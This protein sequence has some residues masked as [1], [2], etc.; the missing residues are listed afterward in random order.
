MK[1]L[2]IIASGLVLAA[3]GGG[4]GGTATGSGGT[5]SI[6]PSVTPATYNLTGQAQ[7]GPLIFGSRIWV[8]ELDGSLNPNGKIFLAQ[9]KDDLGNFVISST[10]GT[11]LVEL[12]GMGYYMDELTG[13][14]ST[15]PV[16]LSA[17]ADLSVDNTPTINILTTLQAPRLKTLILQ[18]KT[19]AQAAVQS[20]TE[21]LAAFGVNSSKIESLNALYAMQINGTNDQDS[22]LLAASAILSK[23]STTAATTNG[24]S[25][26]AEMTY[27]L[28]RIA[29]D[30]QNS[31]ALT[32]TSIITARNTASTQLDLVAVR[33][34]V[35]TYY[36]N[37][38]LTITAPKFEEWVDKDGSGILPRR[39]VPTSGLTFTTLVNLEHSQVVTSNQVTISGLGSGVVA[40]LTVNSGTTIIKNSAA[41]SG[42]SSTVQDGDVVAVRRTSSGFGQ[43]TTAS[44]VAGSTA[45]T[46][47]LTTKIPQIGYDS[48]GGASVPQDA[49]NVY[50]AVPIK[51]A[52]SFTAHYVGVGVGS[53]PTSFSIYSDNAGVPG[54]ALV[55]TNTFGSYFGAALTRLDGSSFS[56]YSSPQAFLGTTGVALTASTVYWIVVQY[57]VAS[58]PG[59]NNALGAN[60]TGLNR[61]MSTDGSTWVNW[62]GCCNGNSDNYNPAALPG[63][64]LAN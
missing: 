28:S 5:P 40:P 57:S 8:S 14:L 31:G 55:T 11:N 35:E 47:Q 29:S 36:A 12:V 18:G 58:T 10:I 46:W 37:R 45:T 2:A 15:S 60:T 7:K 26:A 24:S 9:T 49:S 61:K 25:Q 33:T 56:N 42:T 39:L 16:T 54:S 64:F 51:P 3:C 63:H 38:G 19:Y 48:Q 6:T 30:I 21:V 27:L 32:T 41:I 20:Q 4:G 23:M 22:A 62:V 17:I 52:T 44:I 53:A 50:F 13:S 1:L 59:F 34:N 43:S